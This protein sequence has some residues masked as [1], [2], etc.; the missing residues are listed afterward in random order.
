MPPRVILALVA[1]MRG[2]RRRTLPKGDLTLPA[3]TRFQLLF[4]PYRCPRVVKGAP[5]F[6]EI[7]GWVKVQGF[8]DGP[9]VWPRASFTGYRGRG[10]LIV[11][12]DLSLAIRRESHQAVAH[13][14][15][16]S[17]TVV[18]RWRRALG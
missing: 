4:G 3:R 8:S 6:C 10:P 13:W 5:L 15:G 9:I 7:R 12:G 14:W 2:A 11:C 16:V 1:W 17:T 18:S